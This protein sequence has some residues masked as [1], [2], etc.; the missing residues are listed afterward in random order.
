MKE[1]GRMKWKIVWYQN[2]KD[3]CICEVAVQCNIWRERDYKDITEER[4]WLSLTLKA[5]A[6]L[7]NQEENEIETL[8]LVEMLT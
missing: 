2:V 8:I 6:T 5:C 4:A 7:Q 1:K 3:T